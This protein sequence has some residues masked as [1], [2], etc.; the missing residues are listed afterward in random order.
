MTK[1]ERLKIINI[2]K[3]DDAYT[4]DVDFEKLAKMTI[5]YSGADLSSVLNESLLISVQQDKV[6]ADQECIDIAFKQH[7]VKGHE[8]DCDDKSNQ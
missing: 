7:L 6:K 5:G 4:D 8:K 2:H 1:E 3:V